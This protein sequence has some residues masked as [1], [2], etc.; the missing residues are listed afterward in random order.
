MS[1]SLPDLKR[2][3]RGQFSCFGFPTTELLI[4]WREQGLD[5][6]V[7]AL[8]IRAMQTALSR[9]LKQEQMPAHP[10]D[11]F[12]DAKEILR[13]AIPAS[14]RDIDRVHI[15]VLH[16]V[17]LRTLHDLYQKQ[18][19]RLGGAIPVVNTPEFQATLMIPQVR[20]IEAELRQYGRAMEGRFARYLV[21]SETELKPELFK[22]EIDILLSRVAGDRTLTL[23]C[24]GLHRQILEKYGMPMLPPP[25]YPAPPPPR[26]APPP[27]P[28]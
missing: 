4:M 16:M 6:E 20:S 11:M 26:P 23:L 19:R 7:G 9:F 27:M 22:D 15:N 1:I 2:F 8:Y 13:R 18:M 14:V 10:E 12:T 28:M 3:V 21:N 25:S 5:P 24:E 17:D